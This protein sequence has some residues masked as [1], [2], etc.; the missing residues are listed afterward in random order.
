MSVVDKIP[1]SAEK[2]ALAEPAWERY[3]RCASADAAREFQRLISSPTYKS[4]FQVEGSIGALNQS[5]FG[6]L[7][8]QMK[9]LDQSVFGDLQKQMKALNRTSLAETLRQVKVRD[10]SGVRDSLKQNVALDGALAESIRQ[11]QEKLQGRVYWTAMQR[12]AE[13]VAAAARISVEELTAAL[14]VGLGAAPVSPAVPHGADVLALQPSIAPSE[15]ALTTWF[16]G[17]PSYLQVFLLVALFFAHPV[18][19]FL[20]HRWL[21]ESAE[22]RPKVAVE[23]NQYYGGEFPG[24]VRCVRG[25]GVIVRDGPSKTSLIIGRLG[26]NQPVVV[27]DTAGA[28]L[29]IRYQDADSKEIREGWAASGH[30]ISG[31]CLISKMPVGNP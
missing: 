28:F 29:K 18:T 7:Q 6:D 22:D 8:K 3:L 25:S 12:T 21:T 11:I 13:E 17:L 4:G 14:R 26:I 16:R 1:G 9:A 23:I 2:V 10:L 27:V 15:D 30:L 24:D 19:D 31:A 20:V 5:V